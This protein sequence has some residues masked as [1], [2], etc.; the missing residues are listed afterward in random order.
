M[1]F[2]LVDNFKALESY[3]ERNLYYKIFAGYLFNE[4]I[5]GYDERKNLFIQLLRKKLK[6]NK[7]YFGNE[8]LINEFINKIENQEFHLTF[9]FHTTQVLDDNRGEMSDIL[10]TTRT[11]F[12]S[13][14][15]KYLSNLSFKKDIKEVQAR[16]GRFS[17]HIG[18]DPVQIIL[19]KKQKWE[20]SKNI[21]TNLEESIGIPV[22]ILFW[23]DILSIVKDE[24]VKKYLELQLARV[25]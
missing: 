11:S 18:K 5:E 21:K 17:E 6:D 1:I 4:L 12:L 25:L 22:I 8:N 14:E 9:D 15:C 7:M 3:K 2:N 10:I 13:I 19:V 16:I 24:F 20:F 23:E